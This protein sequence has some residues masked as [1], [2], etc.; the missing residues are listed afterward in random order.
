MKT[1]LI[2]GA[3]GQLGGF[4]TP[5]FAGAGWRVVS[6]QSPRQGRHRVPGVFYV[7]DL[8][9]EA[10]ALRVL[11]EL[12]EDGVVVD[13]VVLLA[14]GFEAGSLSETSADSM[15]RMFDM[16]FYS[17]FHLVRGLAGSTVFRGGICQVI[18][19]GAGS[20]QNPKVASGLVS[21]SLSK[22][23][24]FSIAQYINA[25][26]EHLQMR[27]TILVPGTIDTA[28]NRSWNPDADRSG[29]SKPEDMAVLIRR[30]AGADPD[31][32]WKPV[33]NC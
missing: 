18:F 26:S 31:L 3:S 2:T 32:D 28:A 13:A 16:N 7:A 4:V 22:S 23:L 19:I 17:S 24:L 10:D 27:A 12:N 9:D 6:I 5:E 30:I 11:D 15:R 20:V 1:V 8:A 21:Y 25:D 33:M 29:W 14:G